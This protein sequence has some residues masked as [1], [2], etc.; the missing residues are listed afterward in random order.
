MGTATEDREAFAAFVLD[1]V[2]RAALTRIAQERGWPETRIV[3]GGMNEAIDALTDN[4]TPRLLVIDVSDSSDPL[5]DVNRLARV[6]QENTRVI[7]LGAINDVGLFRKMM[8]LGVDDYLVKPVSSEL[9]KRAIENTGR[10]PVEPTTEEAKQGQLIAIVGARGGVGSTTL[11]V[12]LAWLIAHEHKL[13]VALVDL[14]LHF[15][16]AALS[17]DLEPGRGFRES[18]SHPE[19]IDDLFIERAMVRESDTLALLGAEARLEEDAR[20]DP[21]ALK[22]L[23]G[24]LRGGFDCVVVDVPRSS[25]MSQASLFQCSDAV[26]LVSDLSLAGMRDTLRIGEFI[27]SLVPENRLRTVVNKA[28]AQKKGEL[29]KNDFE[30]NVELQIDDVLPF[31][32][33]ALIEGTVRGKPFAAVMKRGPLVVGL[34]R[35]SRTLCDPG[36]KSTHRG[37]RRLLPGRA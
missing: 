13:R 31:D 3:G 28:G 4:P 18:L 1:D 19:R 26:I 10:E 21:A 34:R 15:G 11:A 35:L 29:S 36:D 27:K 2:G 7:L 8:E 6:C 16:T 9:L 25:L 24:K 32:S 14:D 12:N 23:L 37:W 5:D 33:K 22:V 30:S 17:L 20:I